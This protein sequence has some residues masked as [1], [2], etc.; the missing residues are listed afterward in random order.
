MGKSVPVQGVL[1][2]PGLKKFGGHAFRHGRKNGANICARGDCT[3][4]IY[5]M[6]GQ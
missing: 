3:G 1:D 6:C 4:A 2:I 5:L